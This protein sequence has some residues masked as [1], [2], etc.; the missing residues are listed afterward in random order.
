[1][2]DDISVEDL[3][4]TAQSIFRN[5]NLTASVCYDPDQCADDPL[6]ILR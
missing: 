4:T 1:M 3:Q 2:Y 5:E 6:A